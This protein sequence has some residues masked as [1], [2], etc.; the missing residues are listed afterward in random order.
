MKKNRINWIGRFLITFLGVILA[1]SIWV[2]F[3]RVFLGI[4]DDCWF[5]QSYNWFIKLPII[6]Q[7]IGLICQSDIYFAISFAAHAADGSLSPILELL[8]LMGAVSFV[9]TAINEVSTS[10]SFGI[11]IGDVVKHYFPQ[12]R[13]ILLAFHSAFFLLG[14]FACEKHVGIVA[15]VCLVGL[16]LCFTYAFV[17]FWCFL[18]YPPAKKNLVFRYITYRMSNPLYSMLDLQKKEQCVMEYASYIG[19]TWTRSSH[20]SSIDEES[21]LITIVHNWLQNISSNTMNE[22]NQKNFVGPLKVDDEMLN[23]KPVFHTVFGLKENEYDHLGEYVLYTQCINFAAQ[24]PRTEFQQK[25]MCCRRVWENLFAQMNDSPRKNAMAV[26][27]LNAARKKGKVCFVLFACGLVLQCGILNP[28]PHNADVTEQIENRLLFLRG[29]SAASWEQQSL[30]G[31]TGCSKDT[32]VWCELV[33]I[34]LGA[35]LWSDAFRLIPLED[36]EQLRHAARKSIVSASLPRDILNSM[37][38]S[39]DIYAA[40]AFILFSTANISVYNELTANKF[41]Q[42]RKYIM[43]QMSLGLTLIR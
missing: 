16:L 10:R 41:L 32:A 9:L 1:V 25:I 18:L 28:L 42:L 5:V 33:Y 4:F 2:F 15:V 27:I 7:Y 20:Q 35:F 38:E 37:R 8:K 26:A 6:S 13:I 34:V 39:W 21:F 3:G 40:Y 31:L 23:F 29:L 22:D 11:L 12:H 17:M 36:S 24:N 30:S 43:D 19:E 14:W